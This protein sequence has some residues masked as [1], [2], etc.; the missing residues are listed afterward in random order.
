MATSFENPTYNGDDEQY[1]DSNQ[2]GDDDAFFNYS[3]NL[4]D[5]GGDS[6]I[7]DLLEQVDRLNRFEEVQNLDICRLRSQ[8]CIGSHVDAK[9]R[10]GPSP[11]GD[12]D[13]IS[14]V[15]IASLEGKC[16]TIT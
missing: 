2:G 10:R 1:D 6:D 7:M 14:D 13:E 8:K 11:I 4:S 16:I 12:L 9:W 5:S 15:K 3:Q